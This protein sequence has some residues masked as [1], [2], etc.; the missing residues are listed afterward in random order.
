MKQ[1]LELTY[2]GFSA[3]RLDPKQDNP[4]EVTFAHLWQEEHDRAARRD[5][6][7][8]LIPDL[9]ERDVSVAATIIQWLGSNVGMSFLHDAAK[10]NP[11]IREF[12]CR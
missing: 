12:L 1:K 3:F 5:I 8:H 11:K 2:P 9:T 6:V 10:R 4:R 7:G